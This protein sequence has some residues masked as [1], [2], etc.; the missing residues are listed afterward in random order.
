MNYLT[1][2]LMGI[3]EMVPGISGSTVALILRRY[4]RFI[5]AVNLTIEYLKELRDVRSLSD[6]S[7]WVMGLVREARLWI[8]NCHGFGDAYIVCPIFLRYNWFN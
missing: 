8:F 1:G 7:K 5:G 6:L 4:E 2:V 3:A